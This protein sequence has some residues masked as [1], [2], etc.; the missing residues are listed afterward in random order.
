MHRI[1]EFVK[2]NKFDRSPELLCP[3]EDDEDREDAAD[4]A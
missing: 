1:N 2:R 4:D 3:P